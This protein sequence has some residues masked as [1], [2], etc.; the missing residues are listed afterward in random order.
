MKPRNRKSAPGV[1]DGVVRKKNRTA[2][3]PRYDNTPQLAPAIIRQ[4]PGAGHRH[5]LLKRDIEAFVAL[6]PD[7]EE[8]S[9]GLNAIVLAPGDSGRLGRW[10]PGVVELCAWN[11]TLWLDTDELWCEDHA[12]VFAMLNVSLERNG[13]DQLHVQ[14]SEP[15]AKA[16]QLLH[17]FLHELGHHHD[18]MTTRSKADAAR[19]EG[20]AETYAL[21]HGAAIFQRYVQAFGLD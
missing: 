1:R 2:V 19:G 21:R 7:W 13:P 5:L 9:I 6:L 4:R 20:F 17:I 15:Q 14:F 12:A 11:R 8:L 3:T 10:Y 16:F 18:C